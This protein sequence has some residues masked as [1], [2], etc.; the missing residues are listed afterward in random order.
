M[1]PHPARMIGY[2]RRFKSCWCYFLLPSFHHHDIC[3]SNPTFFFLVSGHFMNHDLSVKSC[4]KPKFSLVN[5]W[6]IDVNGDAY[7]PGYSRSH[8]KVIVCIILVLVLATCFF[9]LLYLTH[10]KDTLPT[11][12]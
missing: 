8:L 3:R 2:K 4:S 7:S 1:R 10:T 6:A 11:L 5:D 9:V 12:A